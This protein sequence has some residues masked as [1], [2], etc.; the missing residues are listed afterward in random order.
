M[1]AEMNTRMT[2]LIG[3]GLLIAG[4]GGPTELQRRAC[5]MYVEA[6]GAEDVSLA[7]LVKMYNTPEMVAYFEA[8]NARNAGN[9]NI[10]QKTPQTFADRMYAFEKERNEKARE[11][12]RRRLNISMREVDEALSKCMTTALKEEAARTKR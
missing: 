8:E 7:E 6:G 9:P 10:A 3:A 5:D 11:I 2:A 12:V 4:C 1:V